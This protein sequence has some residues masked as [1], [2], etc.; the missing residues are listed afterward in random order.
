M[1]DATLY[2][3]KTLHIDKYH[4]GAHHDGATF[5]V[6]YSDHYS[7]SDLETFKIKL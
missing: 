7:E 1:I 4:D 3:K 6:N 5:K 2:A